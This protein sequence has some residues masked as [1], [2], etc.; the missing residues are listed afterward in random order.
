MIC[1]GNTQTNGKGYKS[2]IL[3]ILVRRVAQKTAAVR[4]RPPLRQILGS[5]ITITFCL[6]HIQGK[7]DCHSFD[8]WWWHWPSVLKCW[9]R[10]REL[11][12]KNVW[13]LLILSCYRCW[14]SRSMTFHSFLIMKMVPSGGNPLR[15]A[16]F[17]S[18]CCWCYWGGDILIPNVLEG[19]MVIYGKNELC[20]VTAATTDSFCD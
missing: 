13:E 19:C 8:N 15:I 17:C 16:E 1:A 10:S 12:V 14:C 18:W 6:L 3:R 2:P 20:I 11:L 7:K 4:S 5:H 9:P